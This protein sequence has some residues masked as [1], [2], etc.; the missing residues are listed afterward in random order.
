VAGYGLVLICPKCPSKDYYGM[1]KTPGNKAAPCP[2]CGTPL[3]AL[4]K[5]PSRDRVA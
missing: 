3:V 5:K 4:R 1:L 2:N